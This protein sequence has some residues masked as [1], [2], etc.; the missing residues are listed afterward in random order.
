MISEKRVKA[1]FITLKK[2]AYKYFKRENYIN[3]L[4]KIR[5]AA[6]L[7]YTYNITDSY[8]EEELN[9]LFHINTRN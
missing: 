5:Q 4:D 1:D 6:I 8:G 7:G 2:L 9:K 3:C